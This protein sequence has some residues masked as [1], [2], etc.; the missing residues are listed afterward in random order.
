MQRE[1][2]LMAEPLIHIVDDDSS[3]GLALT[4]LFRSVGLEA[5]AHSS[6]HDFRNMH[7]A[8]RPGCL[9]LDVRL[10]GQSGLDLQ[11][12]M[13]TAGSPLPVILMTGHGDISMS[14]QAMKAGAIDFLTK[15][16]RDQDMLD[17][18]AAAIERD[19]ERRT[20]A[21]AG[22]RLRSRYATLT[23][24][25]RQIFALVADGQMNK[26]SA[27]KL[28]L[29]E[30]TVKVHRRSMMQKLG[31]RTT[32]ELVRMAGRLGVDTQTDGDAST[33]VQSFRCAAPE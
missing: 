20:D 28:S 21:M 23:A 30:V 18:V 1:L 31:A 25:E 14:V 8:E 10:P 26:Q 17:A 22:E 13:A 16:F 7:E 32:A 9:I 29:S 5:V 12:E 19:R 27:A 33:Q 3:L 2:S 24:R 4:R 15:P 6:A 11:A